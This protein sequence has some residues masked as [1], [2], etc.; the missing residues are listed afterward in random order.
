MLRREIK[1]TLDRLQIQNYQKHERFQVKLGPTVT[2]IVGPSDAGK[3]AVIRSLRWLATNRP[4]GD[5][6]LRHGSERATIKA[7][8][9]GVTVVRS[10]GKGGNTYKINKQ[11]YKAVGSDVPEAVEQLV[12]MGSENWKGQHDSPFWFSLTAGEVAKELNRIVDLEVIDRVASELASRLRKAR[13]EVELVG[14]RLEGAESELGELV[15]VPD[16]AEDWG[17]VEGLDSACSK[18]REASTEMSLAVDRVLG[19]E[20]D[21]ET[22]ACVSDMIVGLE[23]LE[24]LAVVATDARA[25]ADSL[26]E[27][28]GPVREATRKAAEDVPDLSAVSKARVAADAIIEQTGALSGLLAEAGRLSRETK[29]VKGEWTEASVEL[30]KRTGGVCPLCGNLMKGE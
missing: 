27:V 6:F 1:M 9:D 29:R 28:V 8:F 18:A 17:G 12:N 23:R 19:A 14:E 24:G 16:M 4:R 15:F 22:T 2:T 7:R 30:D 3:S 21:V 5:G 10:K 11:E 13:A 25:V 26:T 20:R